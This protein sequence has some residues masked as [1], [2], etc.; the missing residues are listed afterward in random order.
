M[1]ELMSGPEAADERLAKGARRATQQ[2]S[3]TRALEPTELP[4]DPRKSPFILQEWDGREWRTVRLSESRSE[5][6]AF[7]AGETDVST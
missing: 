4:L 2:Y 6:D 7:L 3:G 1:G 5:R